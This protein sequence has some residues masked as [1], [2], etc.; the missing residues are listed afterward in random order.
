MEEKLALVVERLIGERDWRSLEALVCSLPLP[1]IADMLGDVK[2]SDRILVYRTLPRDMASDVA[3]YLDADE[4]DA[5]IR[6]LSDAETRHLMANM[7]PDDR[8]HFLGE[9][10]GQV[11]QRIMNLLSPEDLKEARSLLGYPE[12]SVGRLMTPDYVAVRPDWTISQSL[13]QIRRKGRD[14]ETINQIY[15]TDAQW[16]L[17]GVVDLKHLILASPDDTIDCLMRSPVTSLQATEDREEAVR[18]MQRYDSF[19]LPITDSEGILLGIVTADDMFDVAQEEATEDFH[20]SAAVEPLT[21]NYTEASVSDLIKSRIGWLVVLVLMNIVSASIIG[22][23]E[24][25]LASTI[26]LAYFIPLLIDSGGN[27]G[28]QSATLIIRA[29]AT[30]DLSLKLWLKTLSREVAVGLGLGL[31]MGGSASVLGLWRGGFELALVVGLSM[32]GIVLLAN[33]VGAM[34]PF[35]FTRFK[36]DPAVASSPLITTITDSLGLL[37][38][39]SLATV[40]LK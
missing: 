27:A 16:R 20:K 6:G 1:D 10:P 15:V 23:F 39:F 40:F 33:L 36:T 28:S 12:D 29:L 13:A 22:V 25:T 11:T 31:V 21:E 5:L 30:G 26:T 38:Y 7:P 34:L 4:L 2:I 32:V 35:L 9:F 19:A 18:V 8:T 17:I 24:Q 14:S 37:I 3:S